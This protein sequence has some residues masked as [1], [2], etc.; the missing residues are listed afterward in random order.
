MNR[1]LI[2]A[3][4]VALLGAGVLFVRFSFSSDVHLTA[5]GHITAGVIA[6]VGQQQGKPNVDDSTPDENGRLAVP[7]PSPA[8]S[9]EKTS[10]LVNNI[11]DLWISERSGK[12]YSISENDGEVEMFEDGED[13]HN[14]LVGNGRRFGEQMTL[15]FHST[16]DDVDGVLKLHLSPDGKVLDGYFRGLDPTKEGRVRLLRAH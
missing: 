16:L 8:A 14:A 11:T 5:D 6:G 9:S 15:Q 13:H 1:D 7:V 4:L 12:P 10:A 2:I 3:V